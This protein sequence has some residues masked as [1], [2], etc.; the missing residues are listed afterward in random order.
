[1]QR[2]RSACSFVREEL[3]GHST[4]RVHDCP[5]RVRALRR[6][7]TGFSKISF[8]CCKSCLTYSRRRRQFYYLSR[9]H[10]PSAESCTMIVCE[11][12]GPVETRPISTP[13]CCERKSTYRRAFAGRELISVMPNVELCQPGNAA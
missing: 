5:K 1:M 12:S 4:E 8:E 2:A 10:P 3:G 9:S 6:A 7:R 11:R 13:I